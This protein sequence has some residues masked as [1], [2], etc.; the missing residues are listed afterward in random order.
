M[1]LQIVQTEVELL[2][3]YQHLGNNSLRLT[4]FPGLSTLGTWPLDLKKKIEVQCY[5]S[6]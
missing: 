2:T 4:E 3:N 1:N 6:L 5:V